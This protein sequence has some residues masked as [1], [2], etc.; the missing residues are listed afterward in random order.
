MQRPRDQRSTPWTLERAR[1]DGW[2]VISMKDDSR[3][4]FA[5]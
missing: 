1:A 5:D 2:T 3:T 4:V